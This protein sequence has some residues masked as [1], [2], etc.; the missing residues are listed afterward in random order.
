MTILD[1]LADSRKKDF[2]LIQE[3]IK[4]LKKNGK[5]RE[6]PKLRNTLYQNLRECQTFNKLGIISEVKPASPSRGTILKEDIPNDPI[7]H[8]F[9]SNSNAF[10]SDYTPIISE[11]VLD[12]DKKIGSMLKGGVIG[13]SVL[14]EPRKFKG[15]FG[16]L[17]AVDSYT[18]KET[19]V[20]LKDF[21]IDECQLEIGAMCG[22]SNALLI[23]SITEPLK[24]ARLMDK[25]SLEPLVEIHDEIDFE[26]IKPLA[27][28]GKKFVIGINNRNLK[29]LSIDF[30]ATKTL[31]PL[32]KNYFGDSQPVITESGIFTRND[33]IK[34]HA[35]GINGALIGTSIMQGDI[36]Q[37][38]SRL[39]GASYPFVKLCGFK[40]ENL[41]PSLLEY[42]AM[43]NAIGFILDVPGSPRNLSLQQI[44]EL[45]KKVPD[46]FL[47]VI[48]TKDKCIDNLMYYDQ[49]LEPDLIQ[50]HIVDLDNFMNTAPRELLKKLL[51]PIK[52]SHD[53]FIQVKTQIHRFTQHIY[54][55]LIDSSEGKGNPLNI[56][57]AKQLID[58]LPESRVFVAG[59]IGPH[60]VI[61]VLKKLN[62]NGIDASSS[63]ELNFEKNLDLIKYY[64][65]AIQF[66]YSHKERNL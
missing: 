62:P 11:T 60:N 38:L 50:C 14:C 58:E 42:K 9:F 2:P 26:N 51:L 43:V 55:F 49:V 36:F 23:A 56:S 54:G 64:L 52:L 6:E 27:D 15:S 63:L 35:T 31:V 1:D 21:I 7:I 66:F 4:Y 30:S 45:F 12:L 59:G 3:I 44:R 25:Y 37:N 17:K 46:E 18:P 24:M 48:V 19:A 65:N 33:V 16:N 40:N 47:K 28:N 8:P 39:R 34:L 61:E 20:L 29:D 32:V 53:S 22:A 57:L 41:F 10:K 13:I 5:D